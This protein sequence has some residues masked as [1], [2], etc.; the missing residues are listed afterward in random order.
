MK[1]NS[2][3]FE[4]KQCSRC[5]LDTTD[6]DITFDQF[7]VCHYC[8]KY[9]YTVKNHCSHFTPKKLEYLV[10]E[11]KKEGVGKPYDAIV[12]LS[13]GVDSTYALYLAVKKLGLRVLALHVDNINCLFKVIGILIDF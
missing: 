5:I 10:N 4:Y 2:A 11:I 7:G 9:D 13:G 3:N 1:K 12:G 8:H 6:P